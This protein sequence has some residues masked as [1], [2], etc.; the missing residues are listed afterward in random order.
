MQ[1]NSNS[2]INRETFSVLVENK[3]GVLTRVAGLFSGRGYN[4]DSLTVS[5]TQNQAYSRMTIVTHGD[6]AILEQIEKQLN[7]LIDVVKILR[8]HSDKFVAREMLLLKLRI[9]DDNVESLLKFTQKYHAEVLEIKSNALVLQIISTT[10]D[11]DEYIKAL[12]QFDII[13]MARTGSV[14]LTSL[15]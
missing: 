3:F 5:P 9:N 11:L 13:E 7:K 8:L 6:E 15:H 10:E 4:I 2:S 1:N 12:K 14:A